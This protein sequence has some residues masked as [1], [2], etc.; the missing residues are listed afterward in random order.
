[1]RILYLTTR[2]DEIGG[3]QVHI[4][5]LAVAMRARGHD[6]HVAAAPGAAL[7]AQLAAQGVPFHPV[8][9]LVWP[10]SPRADLRAFRQLR[11]LLRDLA[12]DLVSTHASKAGL[13]GRLAARSLGIPVLFTAHGWPFN[14][15][16]PTL[17]RWYSVVVERLAAPFA[18]HIV[19]VSLRDRDRALGYRIAPPARFTCIHNGVPDLPV[20]TAPAAPAPAA[21]APA[22]SSGG[23]PR[24]VMVARF[25]P[26]KEHGQ[27]LEAL[28]SLRDLDWRLDLV[29]DGPLQ[30]PARARAAELGLAGRVDFLGARDDVAALLAR[31]DLFVLA[32]RWEGLPR[33]V[34]EAMRAGLAVVASD[35]GGIHEEVVDGETGLLVPRGDVAALAQR[36]RRLLVDAD[37]RRR[38]GAAGRRRYEAMF[39]FEAMLE[40]TLEVYERVLAQAAAAPGGRQRKLGTH[41]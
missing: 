24:L 3:I 37:L 6:A 10:I 5:D 17:R 33:S 16:T 4:R 1:M 32:S 41:G 34:I 40:R 12:P 30:D 18:D 19:T 11:A 39:R 23:P 13:L 15:G 36:L 22:E 35:V 27:L 31:A 26:P 29:G 2:A 28:A 20:P 38:M 7:A 25:A 14:E 21:P 8:P 9:G